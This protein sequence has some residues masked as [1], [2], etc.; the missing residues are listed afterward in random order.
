MQTSSSENFTLAQC[1]INKE[2]TIKEINTNNDKEM[3]A[4]LFS[5]G[6]YEGQIITIVSML[7]KNFLVSIKDSRYSI[8]EDLAKAII[9]EM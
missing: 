5:L 3:E 9:V 1:E 8:D 4:F 6:C 7:H 2:Y